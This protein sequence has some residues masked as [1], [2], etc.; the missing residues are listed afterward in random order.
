MKEKIANHRLFPSEGLNQIEGFRKL[1]H[2]IEALELICMP[3]LTGMR[4]LRFM[5][6][7]FSYDRA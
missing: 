1:W 2:I 6:I 4:D 3:G 5:S 7:R